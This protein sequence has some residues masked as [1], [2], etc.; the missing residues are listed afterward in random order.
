MESNRWLSFL[1]FRDPAWPIW[2]FSDTDIVVP[3]EPWVPC[4]SGQLIEVDLLEVW[5]RTACLFFSQS[6][7]WKRGQGAGSPGKSRSWK[8]TSAG[9]IHSGLCR[10]GKAAISMAM[11]LYRPLSISSVISP[12]VSMVYYHIYLYIF[13]NQE[14]N[15]SEVRSLTLQDYC[16]QSARSKPSTLL[17]NLHQ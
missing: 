15:G 7:L 14:N 10:S 13:L 8:A 16:L 4:Y 11:M 2:N 17:S 9:S 1:T 12:G 5:P 6:L 3:C